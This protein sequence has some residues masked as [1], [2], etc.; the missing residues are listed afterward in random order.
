MPKTIEA[1]VHDAGVGVTASA[2]DKRHRRD[3]LEP[4]AAVGAGDH[5]QLG[6]HGDN[7]GQV[8]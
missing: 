3:D 5:Q 8:R 1:A 6:E 4:L 7:S 2:D